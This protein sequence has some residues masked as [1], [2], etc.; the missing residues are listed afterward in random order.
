MSGTQTP[1]LDV[2]NLDQ[3][4]RLI[5]SWATHLDYV[6]QAEAPQPPRDYWVNTSWPSEAGRTPASATIPD[7]D[8]DGNPKPWC[9]PPATALAVP[10]ADGTSVTLP[11]AVALTAAEFAAKVAAAGVVVSDLPSKYTH[12]IILQGSVDTMVIRLPPKDTLQGSE[13]DLLNGVIYPFRPFYTALYGGPPHPP[14]DQAGIM[15]LH[16]NRIGEYTMNNCA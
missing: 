8:A 11:H 5:K 2:V 6:S 3:W 13:D 15:E 1:R 10:R 4:G 12:V 14:T 16:A 9:L 7:T